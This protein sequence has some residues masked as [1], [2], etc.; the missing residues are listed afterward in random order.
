MIK[1]VG[2]KWC[3][4]T[5]DGEKQIACHD[6]EEKAQAQLAAIE[7]SKH[8]SSKGYSQS[9]AGV[10]IF[11]S[12]THNGDTYTAADLDEMVA[13]FN[14][15][16][17][18]PALTLGHVATEPGAP[19]VGYVGKLRREG[20]KLVADLI[21]V[22]DKVYAA[23]KEKLFNRVSAE[24]YWNLER[25][26]KKYRRAL[27]ALALLGAHVPAV[28]GL[29]PLAELFSG[30]SGDVHQIESSATSL[31]E[32]S[33]HNPG[34]VSAANAAS[35]GGSTSQGAN[36][37][38][39]EE[40]KKLQE[41]LA[42]AELAK[43]EETK[44]RETAEAALAEVKKTAAGAGSGITEAIKKL[45]ADEKETHIAQLMEAIKTAEAAAKKETED[46]V[47]AE[48]QLSQLTAS[49]KTL[50][51]AGRKERIEKLADTCRIPALR[52]FV[53]TFAD[54]ATRTPD[55]KVYSEKGEEKLALTEVEAFIAYANGHAT[56]IFTVV[57]T[58][59][60][61]RKGA[62]DA[63]AEVDRR[64]KVYQSQHKGVSY[65]DA[66]HAVLE[67]DEQLKADYAA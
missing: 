34:D 9:I 41:R 54:L 57:S 16:D 38:E 52:Q 32:S 15:L 50:E 19:A 66:M 2:D 60:A 58:E 45:T 23:I 29:K 55:L 21:N 4:F 8:E 17:Y 24:V 10:E 1:K 46:R 59:D 62:P 43:A 39:P 33:T 40:L 48:K 22:H 56:R 61:A 67:A 64:T 3:V 25:G 36:E 49:V 63:S 65:K 27:K 42:A 5:H 44:K 31:H 30:N 37:M 6:T 47:A 53:R 28:M 13:A 18:Q 11:S 12:G 20:E 35:S 14:A 7:A 26:G 51:E